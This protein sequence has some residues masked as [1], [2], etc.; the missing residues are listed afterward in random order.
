MMK[1]LKKCER[2]EKRSFIEKLNYDLSLLMKKQLRKRLKDFRRRKKS[3]REDLI[4][5]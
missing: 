1:S 5:K 2:K 4:F 3:V